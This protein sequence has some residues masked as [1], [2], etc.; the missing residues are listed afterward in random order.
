MLVGIV[1]GITDQNGLGTQS[2][3]RFDFDARGGLWHHDARAGPKL[4]GRQRNALGMITRRCGNHPPGELLR[5]QVHH[6]VIGAPK[7]E[8]KDRLQILALEKNRV[9]EALTQNGRK[10][11]RALDGDVID[12]GSE[13]ALNGS[14]ENHGSFKNLDWQIM[15]WRDRRGHAIIRVL[16]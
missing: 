16:I 11:Q 2:P 7:L 3:N 13:N 6:S 4:L 9:F 5:A 15:P 10:I 14:G 12:A 8:G 1:I